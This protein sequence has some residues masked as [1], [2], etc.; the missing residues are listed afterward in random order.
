M[1]TSVS[2][3]LVKKLK[4]VNFALKTTLSIFQ[5]YCLY[6]FLDCLYY[7]GNLVSLTSDR[8]TS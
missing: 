8:D 7:I 2:G 4:V 3:A 6:K 5:I 1:I